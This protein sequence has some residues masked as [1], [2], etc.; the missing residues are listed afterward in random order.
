MGLDYI[1]LIMAVE[2]EFGINIA[3]TDE[4]AEPIVAGLY[5]TVLRKLGPSYEGQLARVWALLT[6]EEQA[7]DSFRRT[8]E[9]FYRL[10]RGLT[11]TLD[12]PL[13]SIH[14]NTPV[15]TLLPPQVRF[16]DWRLLGARTG[17]P[18]PRLDQVS[19]DL[20]WYCLFIPFLLLWLLLMSASVCLAIL[21]WRYMWPA[22]VILM[23][24]LIAASR[25]WNRRFHSPPVTARTTMRDLTHAIELQLAPVDLAS[26]SLAPR[27]RPPAAADRFAGIEDDEVWVRLRAVIVRELRVKPELVTPVAHWS[28]DLGAG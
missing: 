23:A 14:P 25:L 4:A 15:F 7:R 16:R 17:F 20:L 26:T 1:E 5:V 12:L 9:V 22:P 24:V 11:E 6:P 28:H 8:R 13:R 2:D 18:L 19:M 3:E 10:R 27:K 21:E